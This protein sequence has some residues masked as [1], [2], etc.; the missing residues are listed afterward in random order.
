MSDNIG[1][2]KTQLDFLDSDLINVPIQRLPDGNFK[3]YDP[4]SHK[5]FHVKKEEDPGTWFKLQ[6]SLEE[7]LGQDGFHEFLDNSAYPK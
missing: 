4:G 3:V 7:G 2:G 1:K 5:V 6:R